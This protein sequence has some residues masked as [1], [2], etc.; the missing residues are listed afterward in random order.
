[1]PK[2]I[3]LQIVVMDILSLIVIM[4]HINVPRV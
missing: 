3:V 2:F 4:S 1:M